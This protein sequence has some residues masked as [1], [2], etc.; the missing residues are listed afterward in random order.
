MRLWT[1]PARLRDDVPLPEAP[2]TREADPIHGEQRA[3]QS[4]TRCYRDVAAA[5]TVGRLAS[6]TVARVRRIDWPPSL[7]SSYMGPQPCP[8]RACRNLAGAPAG[9]PGTWQAL[10]EPGRRSGRP[11]RNLADPPD[12]WQEPG[13]PFRPLAG[14][15]QAVWE[16]RQEP[17]NETAEVRYKQLRCWIRPVP[18]VRSAHPS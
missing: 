16:R 10:P 12:S 1:D 11:S 15:W 18:R 2:R 4:A 14:T 13:T 8:R 3:A 7:L 5:F 6:R 17:G 9:S